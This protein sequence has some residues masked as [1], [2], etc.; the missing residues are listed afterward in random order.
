MRQLRK[1]EEG[2]GG[3]TYKTKVTNENS[4]HKHK[5]TRQTYILDSAY[6]TVNH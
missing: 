5:P 4:Q 1:I 6:E 3:Q 2:G